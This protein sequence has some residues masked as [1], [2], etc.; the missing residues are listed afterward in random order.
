VK[1]KDDIGTFNTVWLV[2]T[3]EVIWHMLVLE[4][5]TGGVNVERVVIAATIGEQV[6][7]N[8]GFDISTYET[9]VGE[10]ELGVVGNGLLDTVVSEFTSDGVIVLS[11]SV[12]VH[13]PNELWRLN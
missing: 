6:G 9:V 4:E 12:F 3:V 13:E 11:A 10:G 5:A 8:N 1:T 7:S 2:S